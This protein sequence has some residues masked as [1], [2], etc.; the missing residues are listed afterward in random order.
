MPDQYTLFPKGD[1]GHEGFEPRRE[2][3]DT[4]EDVC[5]RRLSRRSLIKGAAAFA[6]LFAIAGTAPEKAQ[7][8][9]VPGRIGFTPIP[10]DGT[11]SI[12]VPAGYTSYSVL[13]W[14]DPVEPGAPAFNPNN[15]TAEAQRQQSGYNCD[16]LGWF[17]LPFGGILTVNHE[18]TN[19]ELMFANYSSANATAEQN[20]IEQAAHGLSIVQVRSIR[21]AQGLRWEVVP[22]SRL[23]R[24]LHS[25]TEFLIT[26]PVA[27]HPLMK[28]SY[29]GT[30]TMVR[31]TL[32][33]CGGGITPWGTL[34][35]AEENFDQYF[36]N[37]GALPNGLAKDA[38]ARFG[39]PVSGGSRPWYRT[40]ARFDIAME[41]NEPNRFGWVVEVDP[42]DP[43]W[44]PRKRTA[45]GRFKHEAAGTTLSK[46]K[47]A[48]V[49]SGDDAR[50][51]YVYKFV[52]KGT[53]NPSDR[54]ANKTLLDEGTLYVA[55]FND[56]GTG[57]WLP[58]IQGENGLTAVQGY[59][60]QAEVLLFAR[61][62]ADILGA[63]Q[64]DRPEDIDVNP[65]NGHVYVALTNNSNRTAEQVD[66]ANP[67][68]NNR[69]GHIIEIRE[70]GGDNAATEFN[71]E[72]FMLCGD[73][74]VANSDAYFAGFD[75]SQVSPL[76]CPDN[77]AFDR[78][79]NLWIATDGMP[80]VISAFNDGIFACPTAGA[81]RGYVR[82]FLSGVTGC[83]VASLVLN[84]NENALFVTI[85]HPGEGGTFERPTS[86]FPFGIMPRPTVIAVSRTRAP[87]KIGQA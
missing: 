55:R 67:R 16:F 74:R 26:G 63:T 79:G 84:T 57:E 19:P 44:Q 4:F 60:S 66:E 6:P 51:E 8:Q 24:R 61:Q 53:F 59:S 76:A 54:D 14:G 87:W 46:N 21:S 31:G 49:Y 1:V 64:M 23:N 20:A 81:D 75:P 35:T 3:L 42:Y 29:D 45:L 34:L 48:V 9:S 50:F 58:L 69:A 38:M 5:R 11:D 17:D 25:E 70:L 37:R 78:A 33:N 2:G 86:R 71:W 7:G 56:D 80:N 28:T 72:I 36:A 40:H 82:Q 10:G 30:G 77:L 62:A 65:V 41:P 73:P 32:N 27:G 18:Y 39:T 85:Q 43:S 12:T 15:L 68:A 22:N 13:S 83:E 47:H 52:S